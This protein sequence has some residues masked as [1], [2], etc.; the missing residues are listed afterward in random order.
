MPSPR[1]VRK[2]LARL[3]SGYAKTEGGDSVTE[4]S[5]QPIVLGRQL[6]IPL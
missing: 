5:S 4:C 6:H 2:P 1:A 3:R